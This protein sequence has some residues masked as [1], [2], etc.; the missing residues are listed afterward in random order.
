M[1]HIGQKVVCIIEPDDDPDAPGDEVTRGGIYTVAN[2][3]ITDDE[4]VMLEFVEMHQ[5]GSEDWWPG[6]EADYFRPAIER[7][8]DISV[9]TELLKTKSREKVN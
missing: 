4:F 6:Y 7:K 9:F 3:F 5:P 1:L 2:I 8:T